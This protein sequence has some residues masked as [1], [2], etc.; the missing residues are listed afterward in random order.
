MGWAQGLW[1]SLSLWPCLV[2]YPFVCLFVPSGTS[3]VVSVHRG[4]RGRGLVHLNRT[5]HPISPLFLAVSEL[6][7]VGS[8]CPGCPCAGKGLKGG[9][10]PSVGGQYVSPPT[11]VG[12]LNCLY[13]GV[14]V[15]NFIYLV[16]WGFVVY[17]YI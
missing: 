13:G 11:V 5:P 16:F 10:K 3:W 15:S 1:G 4:W 2:P 8:P 14:P 17:M 7:P 9:R 12:S 6:C